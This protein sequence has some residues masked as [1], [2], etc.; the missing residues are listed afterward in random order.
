VIAVS[1]E[2]DAQRR[3]VSFAANGHSG[4]AAAGEDVVCAAVSAVLQAAAFSLLMLYPPGVKVRR[5]KGDLRCC[6]AAPP[7]AYPAGQMA[8][9][10]AILRHS[11][12]AVM[13]IA[14]AQPRQVSLQVSGLPDWPGAFKQPDVA[15][16]LRDLL[17]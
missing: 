4:L 6:L 1:F 10:Q 9:I 5:A 8:E 11:L 15:Q 14:L 13:N 2:R 12:L 3:I 7:A 16:A 17:A